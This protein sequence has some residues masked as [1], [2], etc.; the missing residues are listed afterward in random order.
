[1]IL[2]TRFKEIKKKVYVN[3]D[4]LMAF[5]IISKACTSGLKKA[6][7]YIIPYWNFKTSFE[8]SSYYYFLHVP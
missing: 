3:L 4:G 5:H 2:A 8:I 1:M 7:Y 6:A